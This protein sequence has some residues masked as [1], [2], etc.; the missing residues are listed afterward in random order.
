MDELPHT[1]TDQFEVRTGAYWRRRRGDGLKIPTVRVVAG[2]D[3]LASYAIYP[4]ERVS[5]GRDIDCDLVL[6]DHSVSRRHAAVIWSEDAL[7]LEDLGST[8]GTTIGTRRLS[9]QTRLPY[10]RVFYVGNV[11]LRIDM[12][13]IEEIHHLERMA[14]R[15][16]RVVR[17]ALTGLLGRAWLEEELPRVV[18]RHQH[19]QEALG[20]L[21]IDV[22][23][24]KWINDTFG[25]ALGDDVLRTVA[26]LL[27]SE[28]RETDQVV[29]Y[30]GEEFLVLLP[31]CGEVESVQVGERIRAAIATHPWASYVDEAGP[32]LSVT[33]SVGG[34]SLWEGESPAAWLERADQ[35]M[36][37][38]KRTGRDRVVGSTQIEG[39][40]DLSEAGR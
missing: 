12:M 26:R 19:R 10:G 32:K 31:G 3:M 25:H 28:V 4:T 21:F 37:H 29:R 24:F 11:A 34:A 23:H 15:L 39:G 35:A 33:A 14:D 9:G 30:G 22:D 8:N 16:N 5:I 7:I 1:P 13:S 36:Y 40:P 6:T 2:P 27:A 38:A 18:A 20:A 17:D